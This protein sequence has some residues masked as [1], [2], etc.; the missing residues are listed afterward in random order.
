V[1]FH[2]Y[3]SLP[4]GN[5]WSLIKSVTLKK[6]A[7]RK[8]DSDEAARVHARRF[9]AACRVDS[10]NRKLLQA[11]LDRKVIVAARPF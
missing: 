7:F 10:E 9:Q 11:K 1:I 3:V 2:S 4:G 5:S 6:F 8:L